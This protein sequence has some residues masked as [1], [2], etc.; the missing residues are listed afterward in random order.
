MYFSRKVLDRMDIQTV[1]QVEVIFY[2]V[3]QWKKSLMESIGREHGHIHRSGHSNPF[4]I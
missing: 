4:P 1:H 3:N 2:R